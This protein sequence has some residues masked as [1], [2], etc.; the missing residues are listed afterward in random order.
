MTQLIKIQ[1]QPDGSQITQ[2]KKR[3]TVSIDEMNKKRKEFVRLYLVGK[4]TQQ[5]IAAQLN[6][7]EVTVSRWVSKVEPVSFSRARQQLAKEL[8]RL[9]K[10]QNYGA[11]S[12]LISQ[13]IGDIE[14][15]NQLI[16][17]S[18]KSFHLITR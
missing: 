9:T 12:A 17:K 5:Q 7:S 13:L 1:S 15:V 14:R 4:H 8:E 18:K 16:A 2:T 6:V 3:L 11:N 10:Q